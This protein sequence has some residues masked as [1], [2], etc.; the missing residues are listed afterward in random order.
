MKGRYYEYFKNHFN[1]SKST[2]GWYRFTDPGDLVHSDKAM[3]VNF[4][5]LIVKDFRN[6]GVY[7]INQFLKKYK[8]YKNDEEIRKDVS[9]YSDTPIEI[10]STPITYHPDLPPHY[11]PLASGGGVF[12]NRVRRYVK[13][14]GFDVD[15]LDYK[16]FGY[17]AKGEW[18]LYLIIPI[19]ADYQFRTFIGRS[20]MDYSYLRYKN[21]PGAPINEFFYNHD[22]INRDKVG[23]TEGW[24][25]ADTLKGGGIAS[26]GVSLSPI[27]IEKLIA[28]PFSDLY[29]YSDRGAIFNQ[30]SQLMQVA[31]HKKVYM[32]DVGK[33]AKDLNEL[34]D[35]EKIYELTIE[36]KQL[37]LD[38]YIETA[39]NLQSN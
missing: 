4:N 7:P 5:Y 26:M 24:A 37:T 21:P 25:D 30:V 11:K 16:G 23:L 18:S 9:E 17:C 1:L 38:Y 10:L 31:D 22:E 36:A 19:I 2:K 35:A 34:R 20:L 28:A 6:G 39:F 15:E 12:A 13:D 14:R 33:Y 27:Q 8:A 29:Y 32:V 3:G